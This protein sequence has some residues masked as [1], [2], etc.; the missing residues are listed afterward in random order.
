MEEISRDVNNPK[1]VEA[2]K[3]LSEEKIKKYKTPNQ[4]I[5]LMI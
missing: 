5:N 3:K 1:R 2:G 4:I